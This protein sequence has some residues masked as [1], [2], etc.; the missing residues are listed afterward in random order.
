MKKNH[1]IIALLAATIMVG[2]VPIR[3]ETPKEKAWRVFNT[4]IKQ[5]RRCIRG[6]CTLREALQLARKVT[7]A[8]AI[9]IAVMYGVGAGLKKRA[10]YGLKK[11]TL[12][13]YGASRFY[14]TGMKLQRPGRPFVRAGQRAVEA[15]QEAATTA[16][17]W[18][19]ERAAEL[20]PPP[21]PGQ[22][23]QRNPD[24]SWSM[25]PR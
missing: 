16:G 24:G 21:I 4:H 11:G 10:S 8:A 25:V 15:G 6:E 22:K 20:S 3:A 17:K 14:Q 23:W 13:P 2:T 9:V 12:T 7:V 1:L 19:G 5:F 18:V